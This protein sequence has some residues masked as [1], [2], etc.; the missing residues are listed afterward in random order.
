MEADEGERLWELL[1]HKGSSLKGRGGGVVREDGR[2][3][4][5]TKYVSEAVHDVQMLFQGYPIGP[6]S[7]LGAD[8]STSVPNGV[9][10]R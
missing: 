6:V 7:W 9:V 4:D 1:V 2:V 3:V 10:T 5:G 8:I